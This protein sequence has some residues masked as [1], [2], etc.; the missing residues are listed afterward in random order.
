M[1]PWSIISQRVYPK[2]LGIQWNEGIKNSYFYRANELKP[3][4]KGLDKNSETYKEIDA[5]QAVYKLAL[6]GGGYGKLGSHYSWQFD[7]MVMY[8]VTIGGELKMLMLIEELYLAGI[9]IVSVNTD[10]VV[11]HY[12]EEQK[13]IVNNIWKWWE[14][15]TTYT[16][17]DTYYKQIIFSTVN[18]YIAEIINP[19]TN[20]TLY[21]KYKGDF[22]IDKEWH[23]NSSQRIVPIALKR[24][25]IDG[26]PVK[27]TIINH[28]TSSDYD[29]G[30][31]SNYGIFDFCIGRKSDRD[32]TYWLTTREDPIEIKD[33][34]IRYYISNS[35]QKLFKESLGGKSEGRLTSINKGF[36]VTLFMDYD[37]DIVN[38]NLIDYSYYINECNKI[39]KPIIKPKHTVQQL[40]MW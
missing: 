39:I 30:K 14:S 2:H 9:E 24:Y 19:K 1:Y 13:Q 27:E 8:K 29:K 37:P 38:D 12:S 10:G 6:N 21:F 7:E 22:E 20:E 28:L 40:K 16:L 33:K 4:L 32:N 17:E 35:H 15:V 5:E 25:F 34:V 36:N 3:K 31:I 26:I 23:K 18:D 11:I